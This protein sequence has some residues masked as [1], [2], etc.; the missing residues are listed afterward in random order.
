MSGRAWRAFRRNRLAL[1]G[2][3]L[4]LFLALGALLAPWL[5]PHDPLR[6]RLPDRLVPPGTVTAGDASSWGRTTSGGTSSAGS[7]TEGGFR[8]RWGF[9]SSG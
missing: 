9:L 8:S 4:V 1:A 7:S 2:G 3:A 6:G 5:A